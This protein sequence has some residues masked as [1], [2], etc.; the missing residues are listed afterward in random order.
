MKAQY[1]KIFKAT[2]NIEPVAPLSEIADRISNIFGA[3]GSS[4]NI[5]VEIG[6]PKI[7]ESQEELTK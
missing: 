3:Y 5:L 4:Q 2:S 7:R 1:L 6:V